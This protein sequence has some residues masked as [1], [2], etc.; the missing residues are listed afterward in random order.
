MQHKF[1]APQTHFEFFCGQL[2]LV[3]LAGDIVAGL[4]EFLSDVQNGQRGA[5]VGDCRVIQTLNL[6]IK[7]ICRYLL[8]V[9]I[10]SIDYKLYSQR[11]KS[12][13]FLFTLAEFYIRSQTDQVPGPIVVRGG[14][15]SLSL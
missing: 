9:R 10:S 7:D 8:I 13:N 1:H 6:S 5:T 15:G 3:W 14:G 4:K 11:K 12:I 2:L